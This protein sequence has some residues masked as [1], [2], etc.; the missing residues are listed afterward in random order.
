MRGADPMEETAFPLARTPKSGPTGK[1]GGII[2]ERLMNY[3]KG[4]RRI[5]VVGAIG[6]VAFCSI[7]FLMFSSTHAQISDSD[8]AY[9]AAVTV[10]PVLLGIVVFFFAI[11][12]ISRGF[13]EKH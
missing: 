5:F 13:R 6:W 8:L 12:W 4:F 11:P 1:R 2:Q 10:L 3:E 7:G 9:F